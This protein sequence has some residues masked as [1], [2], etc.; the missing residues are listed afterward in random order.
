MQPAYQVSTMESSSGLARGKS[1][2]PT[3]MAKVGLEALSMALMTMA[4]P[5]LL[6]VALGLSV[7]KSI[8]AWARTE[9]HLKA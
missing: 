5:L 3:A 6:L 7:F 2:S 9:W 4:T 1:A 8:V